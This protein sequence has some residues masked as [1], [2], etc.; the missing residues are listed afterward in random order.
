MWH[1][2]DFIAKTQQLDVAAFVKFCRS[3]DIASK[4]KLV[5]DS[6]MPLCNT[7]NCDGLV[8]AFIVNDQFQPGTF[9]RSYDFNDDFTTNKDCYVEGTIVGLDIEAKRYCIVVERR[10]FNGEEISA[11]FLLVHPP[12]NGTQGIFGKT[13][14]VEQVERHPSLI[15]RQECQENRTQIKSTRA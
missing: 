4:F 8:N 1:R 14:F 11:G 7:W 3:D 12:F 6:Q 10:V 2:V 9:V 5:M 15:D 13:A